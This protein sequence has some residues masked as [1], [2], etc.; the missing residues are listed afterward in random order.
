MKKNKIL[1]SARMLR[2][3]GWIFAIA[4][5]AVFVAAGFSV[6]F[7]DLHQTYMLA[8]ETA[9][10]LE[11]QCE[12]Y[13]NYARGVSAKAIQEILDRA[14]GLKKFISPGQYRN[15]DFLNYFIRAEHL[16]GAMILDDQLTVLAQADMDDKDSETM[17][18]HVIERQSVQDILNYP[19]KKYVDEETIDGTP[20]QYAVIA[21]AED[22][23]LI[24]CYASAQKPSRDIYGYSVEQLLNGN[25]FHKNPIAI[26]TNGERILSSTVPELNGLGIEDCPVTRPGEIHWKKDALTRFTYKKSIWYGIHQVSGTYSLY[27]MYPSDEVY[28]N[29]KSFF[30]IGFMAY[31]LVVVLILCVQRYFDRKNLDNTRKQLSIIRGISLSYNSIFLYHTETKQLEAVKIADQLKP[32]YTGVKPAQFV[33][34]ACDAYLE[35]EGTNRVLELLHEDTLEKRLEGKP[36]IGKE[37]PCKNGKWY[38]L[39]LIPQEYDAEKHLR[40]VLAVIRDIS[41]IKQ[42]QELSFKDRLT[43]LHNRNYMEVKGRQFLR[44]GKLP[45]SLIM[46]DCNYLK[47]TNDTLGHEYGDKLLQKV[48]DIF[49]ESAPDNCEVMRIG[50]DEFLILGRECPREQAEEIVE[51]IRQRMQEE[52]TEELPLSAAFGIHTTE[53]GEFSFEKAYYLADQAMYRDKKGTRRR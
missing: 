12:K 15:S 37:I 11:I 35:A 27:V 28:A 10:F 42:A 19:G 51:K 29:R 25:N 2:M 14:E 9:A 49:Q 32:L 4:S 53:E 22:D 3:A 33:L 20:Y 13:D 44:D 47:R 40:T 5:I 41:H 34:G 36:Y 17:W 6:A 38:S 16:S 23:A 45:I 39:V 43:G 46:V 18:E 24:L 52:S 8:Q 7:R 31:L 50:G 30:V 26:V 1:N 21:N 48:A